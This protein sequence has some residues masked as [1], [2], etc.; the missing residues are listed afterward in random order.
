MFPSEVKNDQRPLNGVGVRARERERVR[1]SQLQ[2]QPSHNTNSFSL[3][4]FV[5]SDCIH[6]CSL[7]LRNF[8]EIGHRTM[9][10]KVHYNRCCP[11]F[12]HTVNWNSALS[13]REHFA[14]AKASK[15]WRRLPIIS[16]SIFSN[17]KIMRWHT[18]LFQLKFNGTE[19]ESTLHGDEMLYFITQ[20]NEYEHPLPIIVSFTEMD[21]PSWDQ[22]SVYKI[23]FFSAFAICSARSL[24][25]FS[26]Y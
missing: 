23:Y 16:F 13:L 21:R 22:F 25:E 26:V 3:A 17:N 7:H 10:R 2:K 19:W 20:S 1:Q 14:H 5:L 24:G 4:S 11:S 12:Y 6:S 15:C 9:W 18:T 8:V